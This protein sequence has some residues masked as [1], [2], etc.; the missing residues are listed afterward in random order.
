M[1]SSSAIP[2]FHEINELYAAAG[3]GR[4][5]ASPDCDVIAFKADPR[6]RGSSTRMGPHR[7]GFF[8]FTYLISANGGDDTLLAAAPE[9][10]LTGIDYLRPNF[11][12]QHG[13]T[14]LFKSSV[15]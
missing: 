7:R 5:S 2:C 13:Y 8:Q 9:Q 1:R 12:Q 10:V 14:L 3:F 15:V 11:E 4:I 6:K